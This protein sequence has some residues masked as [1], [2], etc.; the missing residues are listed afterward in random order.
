[1]INPDFYYFW[2]IYR[3]EEL[4]YGR[5]ITQWFEGQIN[6]IKPL[7]SDLVIPIHLSNVSEENYGY[8]FETTA[9]PETIETITN[10]TDSAFNNLKDMLQ[11]KGLVFQ[12]SL[13]KEHPYQDSTPRRYSNP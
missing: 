11:K 5:F 4:V 10:G 1:M 13:L 8:K 2:I 9:D 12:K 6:E 3:S 7:K